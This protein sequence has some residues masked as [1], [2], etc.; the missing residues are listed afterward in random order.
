IYTDTFPGGMHNMCV[1]VSNANGS[2]TGGV[3]ANDTLCH[4]FNAC[5]NGTYTVGDTLS[6]FA[7]I[8][9][10]LTAIDSAGICGSVI[11]RIK[12]GTYNMQLSFDAIPGLNASNTLTF[13]SFTG[14]STDVIFQYSASS[15]TDNYVIQ[16]NGA[17]Y[18]TFRKVTIRATGSSYAYGVYMTNGAEHNT[19]ENCVVKSMLTTSGNGRCIVLYSGAANQYNIIKNNVIEGGYYSM[20]I[21]GPSTTVRAKYNIIEGNDISGFYY[22]GMMLYYQDSLQVIGNYIHDAI[23]TTQY[24][25][26]TY[27]VFDGFRIE[28]NKVILSPSS[29]AYGIRIYY[30]NYYSYITANTAPGIVANN[31]ISL[32]S[33]TGTNYGLYAYYSNKVNYYY[34]SVNISAGSTSSRS[35]YQYNTTSNTFGENYVNNI[36]SNTAGGYAAYFSTIARVMTLDYN[37]YYTNGTYF[38]YWSGNRAN[39]SAFQIAS[40]KESHGKSINPGF[41]S[42]FDL[43][44][45][46]FGL[47]NVATPVVGVTIDIDGELR[48]P[49][50]PDIG[51]DEY[52]PA[53]TDAGAV[54]IDYPLSPVLAGSTPVH[55]TFRNFGLD[56]LTSVTVAWEVNGVAQTPYSWT[57]SKLTGQTVDSVLLGNYIFTAGAAHIKAW[58]TSPNN[59]I[60]GFNYNDTTEVTL[61]ACVGFLKGN[62]TIGGSGADFP[63]FTSAVQALNYCGVDSTVVFNVANGTYNEQITLTQITGASSINTITF[64][65][66][67]GDSSA[68]SLSFSA[69]N[70]TTSHTLHLNGADYIIFKGMTIEGTGTSYARVVTIDGQAH[71]N[72]F[73]NNIISA[74]SG[75]SS[76]FTPIYSSG[77]KDDYNEFRNNVIKN[78]YYAMYWRGAGSS[79]T[80]LEKGTIIENNEF[81]GFYYYGLYLYY[82]DSIIVRGNLIENGSAAVYPRGIYAYYCDRGKRIEGNNIRLAPSSYAYGMYVYY[83]DG[84]SAER[85]IV[86]NNFIS[87]VGGSST[88]YGIYCYSSNYQTI[89]YNSINITAGSTSSRDIYQS[90]GSN[91]RFLNNNL[92][93]TGGGYTY[94]IN[95]PSAIVQSDYNNLYTTGANFVYWSGAH[96]NLASLQASTYKDSNSV[97]VDPVFITNTNLHVNSPILNAGATPI[98]TI[99]VDIDGQT[100]DPNYPD[101]GADEFTPTARDIGPLLFVQPTQSY[102]AVGASVTV[103]MTVRNFG[104]DTIYTF[105]VGYIVGTA[106]PVTSQ[107]SGTLLPG[108][109]FNYQF[110]QTFSAPAGSILLKAYTDLINDG[111][112]LNDTITM[113]YTGVPVIPV[114]WTDSFDMP[115]YYWVNADGNMSWEHG[116]PSG[117]KI[118]TA[119]SSPNVWATKLSTQYPANCNDNLYSPFFD[120]SNAQGATLK[121]WHWVE[122]TSNDGGNIQY[123]TNGGVNWATLGYISDPL[124]TNWYN[125]NIGGTHCFG[126]ST[127]SGWQQST[128]DLSSL[129]NT[130][131]PIQFRYHFLSNAS[132]SDDGWA[133]DDF[134]ITLPKI[135]FDGG[136][137]SINSPVSTSIIGSPVTV[138]VT[139]ENFGYDTL[140]N[141]PVRYTVNNGTPVTENYSGTLLPNATVSYTFTTSFTS[142]STAYTL[143]TWTSVIGDSRPQN[144]SSSTNISPV[145]APYDAGVIA[146]INPVDTTFA[147]QS[148]NVIVK[149][150][151]YGTSTITSMSVEY[152]VNGMNTVTET[153]TGS[154]NQFDTIVYTFNTKLLSS[155]GMY[156]LCSRTNLT[157]DADPANDK[158]CISM[159]GVIDGIVEIS[160][161][162]LALWQNI[163]NPANEITTIKYLVPKAGQI[164]FELRNVIGQTINRFEKSVLQGE[165]QFDLDIKN[166]PSGVYY[167]SIDFEEERLV[168]KMVISK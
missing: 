11:F 42:A 117:S 127:S 134:A 40:S 129:N 63:D 76:Y 51:A 121:F 33:G 45:N 9:D 116:I 19:I 163:P 97:S 158:T 96:S 147:A 58:T 109:S 152:D 7:T 79:T 35:L 124:A 130:T 73:L 93:N 26:Y 107:W 111:D 78:G 80:T 48:N 54:S 61:I 71:H 74:P 8:A 1:W 118:N 87:I 37:N 17:K 164:V 49:S 122:V 2:P 72:K 3:N 46:S 75:T 112:S 126:S 92:V 148:Y 91:L 16:F 59:T 84:V 154:I 77:I 94:Y 95:T 88:N 114:A 32:T 55:L 31:F 21:Y 10:A 102:S 165:H 105:G 131:T 136:V 139:L 99:T 145:P 162:G 65:S 56:T 150:V 24:G 39:L 52:T 144:D 29:Y 98:P 28:G 161:S 53:T 143:D 81:T 160:E 167:Y 151:N 34:N 137:N 142:P 25:I 82:H 83:N 6:D 62:Y 47:S 135:A 86:A 138:T 166:L 66:A 18:I 85:G 30:C 20:Y 100:R 108:G 60:D 57:G 128:Y 168:K 101:I 27:Y 22:Y 141:I 14:D 12:P 153:Y 103:E 13:E 36:F 156:Q 15:T 113:I 4:G 67:S 43:H 41:V 110:Q 120:F 157:N 115:P 70:S 23:N 132:G 146:I 106:N 133:I 155:I 50:T 5:L 140:S 38:V 159:V 149:I 68:V 69:T 104:M 44:T 119:H 90:S 123:T 125:T 89:A 64:Q